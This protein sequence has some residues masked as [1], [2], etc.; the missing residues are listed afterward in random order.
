MKIYE[1]EFLKENVQGSHTVGMCVYLLILPHLFLCL[2][3]IYS[4]TIHVFIIDDV[5]SYATRYLPFPAG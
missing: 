4:L 2:E 5:F 1:K 3:K